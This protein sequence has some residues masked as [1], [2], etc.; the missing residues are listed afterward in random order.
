VTIDLY[1]H[2]AQRAPA[3]GLLGALAYDCLIRPFLPPE[4]PEARP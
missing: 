3:G 2:T 4:R 1:S